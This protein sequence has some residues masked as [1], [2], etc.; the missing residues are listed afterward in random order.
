MID[1]LLHSNKTTLSLVKQQAGQACATK[2]AKLPKNFAFLKPA[3]SAPVTASVRH[4]YRIE[5]DLISAE[6]GRVA[7]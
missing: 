4:G 1:F 2:D 5:V 3:G 6:V 7:G